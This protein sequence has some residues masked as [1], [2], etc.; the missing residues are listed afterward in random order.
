MFYLKTKDYETRQA[1]IK[2][3]KNN[4]ILCVFHY[5]PLHSAPA[6]EKFGRFD[7]IDEH[8]TAD[9]DRLVR[10]PMYYNIAPGDLKK[11]I[12]KTLEFFNR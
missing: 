5:V 4:D 8:T 3:M 7:G 12:N 6:G 9:S 11:V 10:L 2:F 1:Y